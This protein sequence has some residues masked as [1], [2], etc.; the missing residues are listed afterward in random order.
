LLGTYVLWM[1]AA[2]NEDLGAS[3][4]KGV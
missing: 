3:R 4:A 2:V 1:L